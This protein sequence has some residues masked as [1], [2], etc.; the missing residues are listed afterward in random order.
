[1]KIK[2]TGYY[3][4]KTDDFK[5]AK[6]CQLCVKGSKMV[7]F[8]TGICPRHC[9]YCPV[10]EK[11]HQKDVVYAN[12]W[13]ISSDKDMIEECI[14]TEA[15]GSGITG[16][17]PLARLPRVLKYIGMLK[18]KFGKNFHIHLYTPPDLL[19]IPTLK[20]LYS[21][22]LDEIRV[23]PDIFSNK[24]WHKVDLLKKFKWS[25]GMEIPV[26]PDAEKQLSNLIF[27]MI[28]KVDFINL[29]ELEISDTNA[30]NLVGRGYFPKDKISYGVKGCDKLAKK[31]MKKFG[32][33]I[34]IHYC[35]CKLKDKVQMANRIKIRAKNVAKKFD[36]VTN[37][38]MLIRGAI[39]LP[40]ILPGFD[41]EKRL[42]K[43]NNI[44]T[45]KKLNKTK[46]ELAKNFKIP[47]NLLDVDE[48]RYRLLTNI[49]VVEHLAKVLKKM[50]LV[51]AIVEEYPTWDAI[52]LD[53]TFI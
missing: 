20:K 52:Q 34:P 7:L 47:K 39:Y 3:S 5:L 18:K 16:G 1:M 53:I 41:Y 29:N 31:L 9:F 11:K 37:E 35:T 12:E 24:L 2:P 10:S 32:D 27:N 50:N 33:K 40:K 44:I 21:A 42:L 25:V 46:N 51:P 49:G 22:G 15:K 14:L 4:W 38:G 26:L 36:I 6:G 30:Q 19:S 28:G 43:V 23:H 17:D 48:K 8:A 45:L 13:K